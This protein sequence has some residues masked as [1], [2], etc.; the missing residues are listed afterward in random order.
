MWQ[1]RRRVIRLRAA[2]CGQCYC[3]RDEKAAITSAA[4]QRKEQYERRVSYI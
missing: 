2:E 4:E 3:C 1:S